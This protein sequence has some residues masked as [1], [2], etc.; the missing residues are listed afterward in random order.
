M[1]DDEAK[2]IRAKQAMK[3]ANIRSKTTWVK[4]CREHN[5][6]VNKKG[7][8][9]QLN[10]ADVDRMIAAIAA[11]AAGEV[12]VGSVTTLAPTDFIIDCGEY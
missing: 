9:Q 2:T 5:L 10:L 1:S 11:K 4:R 6:P 3:R 7:G 8:K 12:P